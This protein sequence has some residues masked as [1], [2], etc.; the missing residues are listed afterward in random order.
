M[1]DQNKQELTSCPDCSVFTIG[2]KV[3]TSTVSPKTSELH[4]SYNKGALE[5][6]ILVQIADKITEASQPQF[7]LTNGQLT[8]FL[9]AK[10]ASLDTDQFAS[11]FEQKASAYQTEGIA[12]PISTVDPTIT[13]QQAEA[14]KPRAEALIGKSLHLTFEDLDYAI[15]D[16]SLVTFVDPKDSLYAGKI[17]EEIEAVASQVDRPYQNPVFVFEGGKVKEFSPAKDGIKTNS[18]KLADLIKKSV[19]DGLESDTTSIE[20]PV[21]TT[22]PEYSTADVNNLGIKELLGKGYSTFRGS[23]S[24]R[25]YNVNLAASHFNGVLV[26]PGETFS[27]NDTLGDVSAYTGYK[28]AYVISGGRTVLGDGGG[29]CQVSTTLFRAVLDAGLPVVERR[30]HS[31]RVGYYEQTG[32]VGIDATV[33]SPTTDFKFKNDT[34]GHLLIQ[35]FTN[36]ATKELTFE[37]YGTSDGRTSSITKPV[38]S[39][40]IPPPEDLYVDDPTLPAGE[41]KQIDWKAWGAKVSFDY[42]VEKDGETIIQKTFYSN[43][44]PWQSVYLRG[45]API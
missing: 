38:V 45:T 36:T 42:T 5:E 17:V 1:D 43:Y 37:I 29:V 35:T 19:N 34:P 31:Y 13:Q 7:N 44:K 20:I 11:N 28:Q 15:D 30:A 26:K 33:Y 8:T 9:G 4:V 12:I 25:I 18:D 27:F 21:D 40:V 2:L 10:G 16:E 23:I 39:S 14:A 22:P 24:S 32:D 6:I 41:V 3:L